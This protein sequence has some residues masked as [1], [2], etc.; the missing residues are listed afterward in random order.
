MLKP[1]LALLLAFAGMIQQAPK[2]IID[3]ERVT[4]WDATWSKGK[5][6]S[7]QNKYDQVTVELGDASMRITTPD[8]KSQSTSFKLGQ[9]GVHTER[10]SSN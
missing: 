5:P 1:A 4:V 10:E 6:T 3:N 8:G 7:H 2:Q 9:A